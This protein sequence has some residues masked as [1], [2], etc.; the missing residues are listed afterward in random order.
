VSVG[1]RDRAEVAKV[2]AKVDSVKLLGRDNPVFEQNF[3]NRPYLGRLSM[4][5]V[6]AEAKFLGKVM[7]YPSPPYS[8][9][10]TIVN[11]YLKKIMDPLV[12]IHLPE[13]TRE[14]R[15]PKVARQLR[16]PPRRA[17][18]SSVCG[19]AGLCGSS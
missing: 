5:R 7:K 18:S 11:T 6:I 17:H 16:S 15:N 14:N 4:A 3:S 19:T 2:V 8:A 10:H 9:K 13:F 1:L 12:F